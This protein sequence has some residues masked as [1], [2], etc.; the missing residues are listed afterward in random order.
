MKNLI[1]SLRIAILSVLFSL[2]L[3]SYLAGQQP[4]RSVPDPGVITTR[5]AI[6]PAGVQ[7][8]FKGRVHAVGFCGSDAQVTVAAQETSGGNVYRLDAVSNAVQARHNGARNKFGLQGMACV[9]ESGNVLVTVS[10]TVNRKTVQAAIMLA[11]PK[12]EPVATLSGLSTSGP[13]GGVGV[14]ANGQVAVAALTGTDEAAVLNLETRQVVG[15]IRVGIAPFTAVVSRDGATAW[16][17]NWGGR[18]PKVGEKSAPT[19]Q[20]PGA[21]R[22][23]IDAHGIA[24]SG[25]ISRIDLAAGRVTNELAVGLHPSALV[26]DEPRS[27]LYVANGNSNSVS[28]VDTKTVRALARWEIEPFTQRVSG[29]A[30]TSLAVSPDGR[31]LYVACGGINAV[32]VLNTSDGRVEGLIPTAWYPSHLA[33]S[34]SGKSLAVSTLFGVGSGTELPAG[35][36]AS[37]RRELPE[38]QPGIDRRYVHS[39]RGTVNVIEV[40]DATQLAGYTRAVAENNRLSL[41]SGARRQGAVVQARS[42]GQVKPVPVPERR[43]EPSPIQHVVFI[44]KENRTYDQL[45]GDLERGNGDPSL[46]MYG[47]DTAPNQRKLAREFVILDNFYAN[48]GNSADGHQWVTQADETDYVYWAGYGTRDYPKDGNDPIVYA[49]GGFLWDAALRAGK[50]VADFGEYIPM[51]QFVEQKENPKLDLGKFR[52]SLLQQWKAGD[53]FIDR[54]HVVSPIPP[55]DANLVRDFPSYGF[56]APDVLRAR[57]FLRHLREWERSGTM[58][59]LVLIQLPSDH[60]T[61][62]TPGYSTPK[63]MVADNDLALGQIVEGLTHSKFW[64]KTAIFVVEDDAQGGVDH[65][66]G[67]RTVALAISP[68]TRRGAVDSTFYSQASMVKTI[69]MILGLPNLSLFDLI[70]NDMRNSFAPTPNLAPY[71]AVTPQHSIFEVNPPAQA[72]SGQARRDALASARMNWLDVDAAPSEQLNRILWRKERGPQ[73][74]Y[75][76]ARHAVFAPYS[77]DKDDDDR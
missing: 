7:A 30:P 40:P 54:F 73:T 2:V 70:A 60:T 29:I 28:V 16:V 36:L 33:V 72:L 69:E 51:N 61:G 47:E 20:L 67:H 37:L 35:R 8:V 42:A 45:F 3:A 63:A 58:P 76:G 23:L 15:R 64:P 5:Q 44:V 68:Y 17:S 21:D 66:D 34:P 12:L 25:T 38:L 9:P 32:A 77:L 48:G 71:T 11:G 53:E 31:R 41:V 27:R 6:T 59:N 39:Y 4:S 65:V 57:I 74:P 49:S 19:G 43:G 50:T 56:Q 22:V 14:A 52:S 1:V 26:W 18:V 46:V 75:P 13:M 62:T 24:S 55:L 10:T